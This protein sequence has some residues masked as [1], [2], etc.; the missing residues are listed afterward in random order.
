MLLSPHSKAKM[1]DQDLFKELIGTVSTFQKDVVA[2]KEKR[3][4]ATSHAYFRTGPQKC[5][6]EDAEADTGW[7]ENLW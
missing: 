3:V 2:L 5:L 7:Q 1:T 6:C 4:I